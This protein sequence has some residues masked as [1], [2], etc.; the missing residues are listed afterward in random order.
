[1]PKHIGATK[2]FLHGLIVTRGAKFVMPEWDGTDEEALKALQDDPREVICDCSCE[3][4]ERGACTGI[5]RV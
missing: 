5:R 4:D 3:K 1:M 2:S